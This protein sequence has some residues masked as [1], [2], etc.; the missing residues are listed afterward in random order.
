MCDREFYRKLG[1]RNGFSLGGGV[2]PWW[3]AISV[4]CLVRCYV[5]CCMQ[6]SSRLVER[7]RYGLPYWAYSIQAV[8][9]CHPHILEEV[10]PT[11][12]YK[13]LHQRLSGIMET[14]MAMKHML[15]KNC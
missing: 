14:E 7:F 4:F 6:S 15:Q 3:T 9:E 5:L 8:D 10:N 11:Q 2:L 1:D 12:A 13:A